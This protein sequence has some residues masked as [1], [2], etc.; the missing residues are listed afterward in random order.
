MDELNAVDAEAKF[1]AFV[2]GTQLPA[3]DITVQE[4]ALLGIRLHRS[5]LGPSLLRGERGDR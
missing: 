4:A 2:A 1:D 3:R 5:C